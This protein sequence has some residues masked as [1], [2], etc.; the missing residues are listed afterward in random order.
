MD[1]GKSHLVIVGTE[2][3]AIPAPNSLTL[4]EGIPDAWL[5]QIHGGGHGAL[6]QYPEKFVRVLQTFLTTT[7]YNS[8]LG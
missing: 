6:W 5:V 7:T 2:D 3:A 8:D 1:P 4:V